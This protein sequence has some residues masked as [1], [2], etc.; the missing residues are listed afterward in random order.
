MLG[1]RCCLGVALTDGIASV[2]VVTK[3]VLYYLHERA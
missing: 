1:G 3:M 2:G